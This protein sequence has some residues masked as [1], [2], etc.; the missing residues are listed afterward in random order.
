MQLKRALVTGGGGFVGKAIVKKL[1]AEGIETR[2]IGRNRYAEIEKLG[3]RCWQGDIVDTSV[4]QEAAR[5]VDVVFHTA[6]LAGIWGPWQNYYHTNVIGTE[7]VLKVCRAENVPYLVYTSTPSVVFNSRDISGGDEKLEYGGKVLCNYAKSK[8]LAEKSVLAVHSAELATCALRPH[9]I[10]G[11]GD[12]HLLPRIVAS[13]RRGDLKR[14]GDG[15]N[16]VDISYV[17]NVAD[18]HVLAAKSLATDGNAGGKA[19]FISQGHPVNLWEWL[20]NLLVQLGVARIDAAVS[21]GSAYAVGGVLELFY[22]LFKL[23][24]EPK[25]TRFLAEQLAKSHYF[26]IACAQ[27]DLGYNPVVSTEEGLQFTIDWLKTL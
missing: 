19:Y 13:A 26:S 12:P 16:L 15:K 9:L 14:V 5:G 23:R 24:K 20:N 17:D 4:L 7:S 27:N 10:W 8:I 22:N 25:M 1:L 11:P 6:A 21:F 2:V 18:A 3:V